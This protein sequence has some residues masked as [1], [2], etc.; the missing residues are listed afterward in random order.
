MQGPEFSGEE[1]MEMTI[2]RPR[3]DLL[4]LCYPLGLRGAGS[5]LAGL[6]EEPKD[7]TTICAFCVSTYPCAGVANV[8]GSSL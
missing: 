6:S 5:I 3:V 1:R 2:L 4:L 8:M 7:A